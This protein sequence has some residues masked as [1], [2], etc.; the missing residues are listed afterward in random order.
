MTITQSAAIEQVRMRLDEPYPGQW[1]DPNLRSWLNEGVREIARRSEWK[2]GSTDIAATAGTQF[3][4]LPSDVIRVY[5]AEWVPTGT[6]LTYR[7]EYRDINQMDIMW[8]PNQRITQGIPMFY[9]MVSANPLSVELAPIPAQNSTLRIFYYKM[10]TDLA[11]MSTSGASSTLDVPVG[12]EDLPVEYATAM[13]FRKAR[14]VQNYQLTMQVFEQKLGEF[15]DMATRFTDEPTM[16]VP[17]TGGWGG[18]SYLDPFYGG[19]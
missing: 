5:R 14:D 11:T 7:L 15:T 1:S 16:V 17:D 19:Y 9:T 18:Y 12:W 10:P 13:A 8:G 4:V 6:T 3:Y 2:R